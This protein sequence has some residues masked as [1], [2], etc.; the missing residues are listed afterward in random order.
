MTGIHKTAS[1]FSSAVWKKD[2]SSAVN[3]TFSVTGNLLV[4][5]KQGVCV[6]AAAF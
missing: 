1:G 5:E 6:C 2:N 3:E 4:K